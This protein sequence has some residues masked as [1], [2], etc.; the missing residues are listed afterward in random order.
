MTLSFIT[1]F[2]FYY[3][4]GFNY[5]DALVNS[6]PLFIISSAIAIP[7][8]KNIAKSQK[9]FVIFESSLSD[10]FG[11]ILFNF[12]VVNATIEF[13][14][15]L[16]FGL[17][18]IIMIAISFTASILLA[19][20]L[21]KIKHNIKFIPI[22]MLLIIIYALSKIY[23]L[24]ALIFIVVFGLFLGNLEELKGI[25]WIKNLKPEI[26]NKEVHKFREITAEATF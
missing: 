21:S 12:F 2:V 20:L 6:I 4:G 14:S 19:Y 13:N 25:K 7:S 11:V 24:P 15:F 17:E 16:H 9:E 10:I 26:L 22:I 8:A 18:L 3:Y 5:K 1:A 23:H